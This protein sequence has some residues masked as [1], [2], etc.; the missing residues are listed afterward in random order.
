MVVQG[1]V[2]L[3]EHHVREVG[4]E[5]VPVGEFECAAAQP[6]TDVVAVIQ[7]KQHGR[8][9]ERPVTSS[10][11]LPTE[12]PAAPGPILIEHADHAVPA[13]GQERA[14]RLAAIRGH[15]RGQVKAG[16][17]TEQQQQLARSRCPSLVHDAMIAPNPVALPCE[18]RHAPGEPTGT[19]S[20]PSTGPAWDGT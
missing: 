20:C 6:L 7:V 4:I 15:Q 2:G 14:G 8:R 19:A 18:P 5:R 12:S 13:G 16:L 10:R 3:P 9:V 1:P 11:S 17:L